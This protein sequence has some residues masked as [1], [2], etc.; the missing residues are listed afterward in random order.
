MNT[1]HELLLARR[2]ATLRRYVTTG[3]CYLLEEFFDIPNIA[4]EK[5]ELARCAFMYNKINDVLD[6]NNNFWKE[7]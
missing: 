2:D 7:L 1:E 5:I 6:S 3:H 4:E